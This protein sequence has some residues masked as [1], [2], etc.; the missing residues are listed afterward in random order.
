M[1]EQGKESREVAPASL[2]AGATDAAHAPCDADRNCDDNSIKV[3][4]LSLTGLSRPKGLLGH[5]RSNSDK[6]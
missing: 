4:E 2:D 3:A 5:S 6:Y 1:G